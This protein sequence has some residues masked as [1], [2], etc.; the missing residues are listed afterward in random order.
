MEPDIADGMGRGCAGDGVWV[1]WCFGCDLTGQ[2]VANRSRQKQTARCRTHAA[3]D[4]HQ[5]TDRLR[6]TAENTKKA[7]CNRQCATD[8][9]EQIESSKQKI[10]NDM[11]QK[12]AAKSMPTGRRR[13]TAGRG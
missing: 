2:K 5:A 13:K 9:T 8:N 10:T 4:R 6:Q 7:A 1:V 3:A 11:Q 12:T